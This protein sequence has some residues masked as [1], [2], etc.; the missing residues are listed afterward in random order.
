[1]HNYKSTYHVNIS[2]KYQIVLGY[3]LNPYIQ[4]GDN[5]TNDD[6]VLN[7]WTNVLEK[8][9]PDIAM[10]IKISK[11]V[12]NELLNLMISAKNNLVYYE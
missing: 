4:Y 5:A 3:F 12:I 8:M 10:K 7:G 2:L 9:V 6:E 1:M 11:E